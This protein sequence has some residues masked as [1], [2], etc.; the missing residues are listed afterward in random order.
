MQL[1]EFKE[2]YLELLL[3]FLWRQWSALGVAGYGEG[4]DPWV[5]D[6]EAL[7]LFSASI[8]RYDSRLFDEILDWLDKNERFINIQRLRNILKEED[9]SSKRIVSA[10]AGKMADETSGIKWKKLAGSSKTDEKKPLFLMKNGQPLP[11]VGE[12]DA[13]FSSYGFSRNPIKNRGLSQTFLYGKT[14]SLLLQLRALFGVNS[15]AE[16]ML[17]L[18][19]NG[20]G[21]IAEIAEQSYYSWRS[22]QEVLFELGRSGILSFSAAKKGRV[23][24]M[25]SVLWEELLLK[26]S[27]KPEKWICW[28]PLFRALEM[29]LEKL[30]NQNFLESSSLEQS[31]ELRQMVEGGL[32]EKFEKAGFGVELGASLSWG[33]EE[34]LGYWLDVV[35]KILG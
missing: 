17:F 32:C 2:Q 31:A 7:L 15:R 22:V 12:H 18:I 1:K 35:Q 9:F 33:G 3:R 11:V 5:L 13:I 19:V 16:T 25:Q 20:Q 10:I 6:P 4:D 29:I 27:K 23:Y 34:F 30:N 28:P 14:N 24:Y 26:N 8:A 21:T